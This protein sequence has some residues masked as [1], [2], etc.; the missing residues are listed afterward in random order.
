MYK[1]CSGVLQRSLRSEK[2]QETM[3]PRFPHDFLFYI[4]V[5]TPRGLCEGRHSIINNIND[6]IK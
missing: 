2:D 5:N 1:E 4:R 6:I 3:P